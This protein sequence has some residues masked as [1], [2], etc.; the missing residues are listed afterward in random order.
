MRGVVVA[1]SSPGA[2]QPAGHARAGD[3]RLVRFG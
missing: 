3:A 1:I 2:S